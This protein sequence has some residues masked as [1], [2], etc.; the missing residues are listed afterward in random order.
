MISSTQCW[1]SRSIRQVRRGSG[2]KKTLQSWRSGKFC[3]G[4]VELGGG[5]G[6]QWWSLC[7]WHIQRS[8]TEVPR[9]SSNRPRLLTMWVEIRLLSCSALRGRPL[10]SECYVLLGA[11]EWPGHSG[12]FLGKENC[13]LSVHPEFPK[14]VKYIILSSLS[15]TYS[16]KTEFVTYLDFR[17]MG[18]LLITW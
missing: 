14:W 12:H 16:D 18:H 8:C 2:G 1:L 15:S 13:S 4:Q 6:G 11:Q 10:S 3:K 17:T 9:P 5:A 7:K